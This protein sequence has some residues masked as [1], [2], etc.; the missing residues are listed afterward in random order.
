VS[1]E[2]PSN[3]LNFRLIVDR[4][5]GDDNER[6]IAAVVE[7][8]VNR[9]NTPFV[10]LGSI[11]QLEGKLPYAIVQ[12]RKGDWRMLESNK[13]EPDTRP[14]FSGLRLNAIGNPLFRYLFPRDS[15][16]LDLLSRSCERAHRLDIYLR[17][18]LELHPDLANLPWELAE[19]PNDDSHAPDI[20]ATRISI[21]R[22][23]GDISVAEARRIDG[24]SENNHINEP[25]VIIVKAARR[26]PPL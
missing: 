23:L 18:Q 25:V 1:E 10:D 21:T 20:L 26:C 3:F 13:D 4:L 16:H 24:H 19:C 17:I 11:R 15:R 5:A 22:Y 6:Y 12:S 14:A 9:S 7:A 2:S 8:P